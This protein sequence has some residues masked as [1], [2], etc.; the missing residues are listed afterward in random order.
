MVKYLVLFLTLA[1][2][3]YNGQEETGPQGRSGEQ[4]PVGPQGPTGSQG[5]KGEMGERGYQGI[6]GIA[7]TSGPEG[8]RGEQGEKGDDGERGEQ[9][10]DAAPCTVEQFDDGARI[11]C[12]DGTMADIYHGQDGAPGVPGQ[13]GADGQDGLDNTEPVY[14]GYYCS[15]VVLRI[16]LV[17]YL[18]HG[19]LIP[20]STTWYKVSNTCEIRYKN[21]KVETRVP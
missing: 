14:I 13:P 15:R 9:G 18:I 20:L 5:E 12:P 7:G 10:E 3:E 1:C 16:G 19:A 6:P 11:S 17:P 4:G 21:N 2:G 8:P